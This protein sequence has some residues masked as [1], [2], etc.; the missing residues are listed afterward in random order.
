MQL[1]NAM[2][3][4]VVCTPKPPPQLP[5]CHA[6]ALGD[7]FVFTTEGLGHN[8]AQEALAALL[9]LL[10]HAAAELLLHLQCI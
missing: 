2:H 9:V 4:H 6:G 5:T 3:L 8:G 1:L 7:V 10:P